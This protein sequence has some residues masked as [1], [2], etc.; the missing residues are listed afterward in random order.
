MKDILFSTKRQKAEIIEIV[1][2]FFAAFLI[3]VFSIIYYKTSWSEL[4]TQWLWVLIITC[5]LYII[6]VGVRICYYWVRRFF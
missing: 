6:S 3:N 2:C 4:Y 5:V 1:A